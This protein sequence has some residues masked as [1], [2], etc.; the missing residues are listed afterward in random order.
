MH[1]KD[2]N[3]VNYFAKRVPASRIMVNSPSALGGIGATTSLMP[4]L[5]LGCGAAGGSAT[6]EN[7]GPMQ[8]LNLK[9][10][11]FGIKEFEDIKAS[12]PNCDSGICE[13]T[14]NLDNVDIESIVKNVIEEMKKTSFQ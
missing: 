9:Y 5:T 11:A 4:S 12:V 8:L 6:S 10:V 2:D 1:T 7:V 14:N 13:T 3:I